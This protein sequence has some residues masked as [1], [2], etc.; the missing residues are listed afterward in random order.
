MMYPVS[1]ENCR[2]EQVEEGFNLPT[3]MKQKT[4][5]I[6]MP[7]FCLLSF[8]KSLSIGVGPEIFKGAAE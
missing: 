2:E 5:F 8:H 4:R 7:Y 6:Y 1:E 3:D